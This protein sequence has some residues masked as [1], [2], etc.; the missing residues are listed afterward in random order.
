MLEK[1][2]RCKFADVGLYF[3][4]FGSLIYAGLTADGEGASYIL[5]FAK[6]SISEP[7]IPLSVSVFYA[8]GALFDL[9]ATGKNQ[10]NLEQILK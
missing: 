3:G 8:V 2:L 10:K 7:I 5:D 6:Q 1:Q 9:D 4:A